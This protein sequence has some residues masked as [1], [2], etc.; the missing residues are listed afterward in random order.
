MIIT[1]N[2]KNNNNICINAII[3]QYNIYFDNFY[4]CNNVYN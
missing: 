3:K 2:Y 4:I 1:T